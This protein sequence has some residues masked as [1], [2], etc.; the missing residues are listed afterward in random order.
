[1]VPTTRWD[2]SPFKTGDRVRVVSCKGGA[3]PYN[4]K[5]GI[6]TV[7][8]GNGWWGCVIDGVEVKLQWKCIIIT[9]TVL[10]AELS[11]L[12]YL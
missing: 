2:T 8:S 4:G 6:L 10:A 11:K 3:K 5:T 12:G 1:M 9:R 7:P